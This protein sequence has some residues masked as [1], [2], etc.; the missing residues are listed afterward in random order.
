MRP[1][2]ALVLVVASCVSVDYM[3]TTYPATDKV[4]LY[5]SMEDVGRA[6]EVMGEAEAEA[7]EGIQMQQIQEKLVD[8]AKKRGADAIV[9]GDVGKLEKSI[10]TFSTSRASGDGPE[11]YVDKQGQLHHAGKSRSS[12]TATTTIQHDTVVK[13]RLIK[14]KD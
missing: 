8:D 7:I 10:T 9:I 3:G 11:Y 4:D 2:L 5:F 1:V 12:T 14:Y 6:H 13:A